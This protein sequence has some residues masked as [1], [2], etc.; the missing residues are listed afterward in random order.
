MI[1]LCQISQAPS[2]MN[3]SN[4]F[5]FTGARRR[6][7]ERNT[8]DELKRL[9]TQLVTTLEGSQ[10]EVPQESAKQHTRERMKSTIPQNTQEGYDV[11]IRTRPSEPG[12]CSRDF[13]ICIGN[14]IIRRGE[15]S[16]NAN[17]S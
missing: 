1:C 8:R 14:H 6:L 3:K 9:E 13:A 12:T 5:F 4:V 17:L 2:C 16:R 11:Q 15:S 10:K 7:R